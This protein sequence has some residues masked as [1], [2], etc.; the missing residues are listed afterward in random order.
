L[1][2]AGQ[3][4]T[5]REMGEVEFSVRQ[6]MRT[7]VF[8]ISVVG[9]WPGRI[10]SPLFTMHLIPYLTD[11]GI[12]RVAATAILG[13]M[14][15]VSAPARLLGGI[16]A[17]RVSLNR[18]KYIRILNNALIWIGLLCLMNARSLS[19]VYAYTLFRGLGLGINAG[20]GTQISGR[21]WGRKGYATI[22]GIRSLLGIPVGV[23]AP[24]YVGWLYD[25][26]GSYMT[27][28]NQALILY[29]ISIITWYFYN[30]PKRGTVVSDVKEFM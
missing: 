24:I 8:W 9:F 22:T 18:L 21:Y 1:I 26:T 4:Y 5:A 6:A 23:F 3:E 17:D 27:A 11:M 15:L 13:V 28:F 16:L 10:A 19:L 12:D 2:K 14:V 30:P 20:A 29:I 7:K 25:T